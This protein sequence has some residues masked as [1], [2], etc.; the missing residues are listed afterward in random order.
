MIGDVKYAAKHV[1]AQA[2]RMA[3]LMIGYYYLQESVQNGVDMSFYSSKMDIKGCF[4][5]VFIY[6]I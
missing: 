4:R 5:M 6:V 1:L 2:P 3:Y